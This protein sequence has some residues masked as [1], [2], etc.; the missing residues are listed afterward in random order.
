MT[1]PECGAS[2]TP[3]PAHGC[4]AVCA[5]CGTAFVDSTVP[6]QSPAQLEAQSIALAY[7]LQQEEHA[8]FLQAAR[9]NSPSRQVATTPAA[10]LGAQ[11]GMEE[12]DDESL[13]LAIQL[14]AEEYQW[15]EMQ[16]AREAAAS[17]SAVNEDADEDLRLAQLLQAEEDGQVQDR[18]ASMQR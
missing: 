10:E 2:D 13:Q 17:M 12:D 3:K 9:A 1:C 18:N 7:K 6:A 14:Q 5:Q 4:D 8:A 16:R 11:V 15:Q